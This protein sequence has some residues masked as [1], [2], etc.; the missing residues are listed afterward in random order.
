MGE[1]VRAAI[2]YE[3]QQDTE[4]IKP[5]RGMQLPYRNIWLNQCDDGSESILCVRGE[6]VDG[7]HSQGWR[8]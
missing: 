2:L 6:G 5:E 1:E 7:W 8:S 4:A 3:S